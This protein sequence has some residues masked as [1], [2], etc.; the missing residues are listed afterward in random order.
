[1][2]PYIVLYIVNMLFAF[3]AEQYFSRKNM[4]Y[5]ISMFLIVICNAVILGMRD[6]GVGIDTTVYI[7]D[8]FLTSQ[9]VHTIRSLFLYD[10]YDKG[11]LLLAKISRLFSYNSQSLLVVTELFIMFFTIWGIH[12]YKEKLG[13]NIP[14]FLTLYWLIFLCHSLNLMRQYCAIS[15]LFWGFSQYLSQKKIIYV[16]SQLLAFFLHSSSL[17]FVLVP[18]FY[19]LSSLKSERI[20]WGVLLSIVVMIFLGIY[21][22]HNMLSM[23]TDY[24]IM[25]DVYATRYGEDSIY[26]TTSGLVK[27]GIRDVVLKL[28]PLIILLI[29]Y[30]KEKISSREFF[31][32]L[33]LFVVSFS[34]EQVRYVMFYMFR[35]AHYVSIVFF[36]YFTKIIL[37]K[38]VPVFWKYMYFSVLIITFYIVFM[39]ESPAGWSYSYKSKILGI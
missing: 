28:I 32:V 8:Y 6:F 16:I 37:E 2:I 18:F 4:I 5:Y 17:I 11:Y 9:N 14:M 29:T 38:K 25:A 33:S 21:F 19:E 36:I 34:I 1:M 7:D 12:G 23:I 35:L 30:K 27:W 3:V 24:H 26:A 31:Y 10:D 13:I 15:L 22:F 39:K 20:K